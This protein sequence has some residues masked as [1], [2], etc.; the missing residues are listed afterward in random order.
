MNP[1][2]ILARIALAATT[3]GATQTFAEEVSVGIDQQTGVAVTIYNEDL[4]LIREERKVDLKAGLNELAFI[5]VAAEIRPQT[6]Q[7][8]AEGGGLTVTEQNFDFDLLTPQKLLEKSV[9]GAIRVIRTNPATGADSSEEAKVLSVSEGMAV[10]QT[11]DR[12]ETVLPGRLIFSTVPPNL[13]PRPTLVTKALSDRAGPTTVT[14]SYLSH[15]LSWQADYTAT[16]SADE[17]TISLSGLVTLTNQSGVTYEDAEL[18]LVAGNVNQV[19][20]KL[21]YEKYA[22]IDIQ[23]AAGPGAMTEAPTF[24]YHIY[25]L[26]T[27]LTIRQNQTKQVAMM[28]AAGVPVTKQYWITNASD[29]W[30][31]YLHDDA[32]GVRIN[33]TVKLKLTNNQESRLGMPLPEGVVRAYKLDSRGKAVFV[34]EDT[35]D[36]T[37]KNENALL[38]LGQ[39]FDITARV[40]QTD[41]K[42][43]G[44]RIYE[45]AYE[46]EVRNAKKEVVTVELT[47]RYAGTWQIL[48]ESQEHRKLDASTIVWSVDVPAEGSTK[49]SYRIRSEE[50]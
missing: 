5:D 48:S 34:G 27:P 30:S 12:I 29:A 46:I 45:N 23:T 47:E 38:T 44:E 2:S 9:G 19:M 21:T 26:D 31:R 36:H 6:A 17:M 3:L 24:E 18:E 16:L 14:L 32:E 33:A 13:R 28:A 49:L 1:A 4:A 41:Y 15:G 11:G 35:I 40:K 20:D 42:R 39:A 22:N 37:P 7:L 10:L 25:R 50:Y 43:I 8:S